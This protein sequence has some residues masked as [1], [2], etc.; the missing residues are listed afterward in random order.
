M[1]FMFHLFNSN[2][3]CDL[4]GSSTIA[5]VAVAVLVEPPEPYMLWA[6]YYKGL[7]LEYIRRWMAIYVYECKIIDR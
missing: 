3:H 2:E 4:I 6:V 7:L 1:W 5:T